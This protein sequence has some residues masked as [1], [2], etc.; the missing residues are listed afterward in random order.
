MIHWRGHDVLYHEI[1]QLSLS[2]VETDV[3]IMQWFDQCFTIIFSD[4]DIRC[5]I[6]R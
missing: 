1:A 4:L 2:N 5:Q 6:V 3:T